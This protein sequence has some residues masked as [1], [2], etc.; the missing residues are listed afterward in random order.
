MQFDLLSVI[1][2]LLGILTILGIYFKPRFYW[3][4][5]RLRR[6]RKLVGDRQVIITYNI[7]AV[8]MIVLGFLGLYGIL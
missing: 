6:A 8:I 3:E 5:K 1:L 2:I 4:S 7:L